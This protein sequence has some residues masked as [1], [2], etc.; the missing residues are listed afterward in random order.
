LI[1]IDV[2]KGEGAFIRE[3]YTTFMIAERQL[4][5]RNKSQISVWPS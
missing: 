2:S 3:C 5:N 4:N 1:G